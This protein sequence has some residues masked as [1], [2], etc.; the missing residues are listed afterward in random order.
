MVCE[1]IYSYLNSTTGMV[2]YGGTIVLSAN[3]N[4]YRCEK[5]GKIRCKIYGE[6]RILLKRKNNKDIQKQLQLL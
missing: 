4:F 2:D 3:H 6:Y 5:C 1:H